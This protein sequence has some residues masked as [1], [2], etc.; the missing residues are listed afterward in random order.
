MMEDLYEFFKYIIV[1][2]KSEYVALFS[3]IVTLIIFI[4][5]RQAELRYK[6]YEERKHEY[7]K[8]IDF[9]NITYTDPNKMKFQKNGEPSSEMQQKFFDVGSSLMLY[10]SKKL[11]K[12]YIFFRD[13]TTHDV[14]KKS[15]YYDV[16]LIT[17]IIADILKQIRKEI[18]L[19]NFNSITSNEALAFFINNIGTIPV[20][21]NRAQK[22]NYKIKMLK[23]EL[24]FMDR[25]YAVLLHTF[26]YNLI[27]PIFGIMKCFCLYIL[28][29][30]LMK[31]IELC[32]KQNIEP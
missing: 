6:K 7:K 15:K 20:E 25:L 2:M 1:N 16:E 3:V 21:K 29:L 9:L 27:K 30:P 22:M 28:L 10:A 24:F 4:L 32:K 13:F 14:F 31:I 11:Y 23:V 19:A 18:G 26:F 12:K 5:N 17:Y 8:L